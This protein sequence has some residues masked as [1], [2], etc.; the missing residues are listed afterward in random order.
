MLRVLLA[1]L[2]S[3]PTL[4]LLTGLSAAAPVCAPPK[5]LHFTIARKFTR[6]VLGFTEGLEV[7]DG[8]IYESTGSLFGDTR[9]MRMTPEGKV[10]VLADFGEKFFGEGL[11]I[12]HDQIYQ[13]SWK[14]HRVFVYDLAGKL[15]R[16]MRNDREGWG[17]THEEGGRAG[18]RLLFSDGS[19]HLYFADP[20]TFSTL[21]SVEVRRGDT[22]V[23]MINE[24]E[25]VDGKVW[26]NVFETRQIL[27]IDPAS[28][29][30]EAEAQ[31]DTLWDHMRPEERDYTGEDGNFVLNG[32]AWDEAHKLFYLTGKVWPMVFAGRFSEH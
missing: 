26:A 6:D 5:P 28:G 11:T 4:L 15:L 14:D 23:T 9:L 24:L 10:S 25:W 17:L 1:G 22:P 31:M 32:I 12:L 21:G 29:C 18:D 13:L 7:H 19:S 30:V 20:R 27:R 3:L 8:E 16:T 2:L